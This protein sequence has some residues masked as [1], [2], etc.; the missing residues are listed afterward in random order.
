V[1]FAV[2]GV[3]EMPPPEMDRQHVAGNHV[4]LQC[5]SA[6]I[7][8]GHLQKGS[9]QVVTG[10]RLAQGQR[11]G[12][13]GNTGNT[14]EPHLHIHAQRPGTVEAPLFGEPLPIRFDQ[15]HPVRNTWIMALRENDAGA[16]PDTL[17]STV[18][19]DR[20]TGEDR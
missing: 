14:A 20:S 5:G 12:R 16:D 10:Q 1:L 4:I 9:L 2:D 17:H 19:S 6:W 13:V 3:E 7:V 15:R 11:L 8:L 18:V